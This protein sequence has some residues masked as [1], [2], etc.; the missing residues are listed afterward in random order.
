MGPIDTVVLN[1]GVAVVFLVQKTCVEMSARS[2]VILIEDDHL[3]PR[4][5]Q[6]LSEDFLKLDHDPPHRFQ[7]T[8]Y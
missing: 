8:I 3:F 6:K 5:S 2:P 4:S 7:F 1:Q